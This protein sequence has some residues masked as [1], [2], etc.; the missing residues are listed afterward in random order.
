MINF[1]T[2][3]LATATAGVMGI[4]M[5]AANAVPLANVLFQGSQQLSDNS[6]EIL[7]NG[8]TS[9]GATTLDVG[10][11]L[12]GV[13]SIQTVEQG[14]TT[15]PVG[16][17]GN[18]ELSAIFD[19][20]VASKSCSVSG[21]SF[22][23]KPT[24]TFQT[25]VSGLGFANPSSNAMIAFFEDSTPD[26]TRG[27]TVAAGEASAK[28]GSKFWLFG[29]DTSV[30]DFWN[31]TAISDDLALLNSGLFA[32]TTPVGSFQTG[33][34]LLDNPSGLVLTSVSCTNLF[35]LT[36]GSH[37]GGCA[38]GGLSVKSGGDFDMWDDVNITVNVVPEPATIGFL[39]LAL[40]G[41]GF[42]SR[43]RK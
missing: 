18:N 4:G 38:E 30:G 22:T 31:A 20:E 28:D 1:R 27:G 39:G 13:L 8:P 26:F 32:P 5:S 37:T 25:E 12:R 23:F 9:T 29:M 15:R 43:R 42:V 24:A 11:R 36:S 17:A 3:L 21:C 10:D 16:T 41:M 34:S 33:L 7:I 2:A 6:A 40:A 14:T 19:I 35:T